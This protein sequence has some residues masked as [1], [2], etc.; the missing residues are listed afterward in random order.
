[1]KNLPSFIKKT[2]MKKISIQGN[3]IRKI[4]LPYIC[5]KYLSW[6]REILSDYVILWYCLTTLFSNS[7]ISPISSSY[8][9]AHLIEREVSL[10]RGSKKCSQG[11][12]I[13]TDSK[14]KNIFSN[15][16][17]ELKERNII[18]RRCFPIPQFPL[19]PLLPTS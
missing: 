9:L 19:P 8:L 7:P 5:T 1:M 3:P 11:Y 18:W 6:K 15:Q 2:T 16:I 17:T 13:D 12:N 4:C 10:H 14:T